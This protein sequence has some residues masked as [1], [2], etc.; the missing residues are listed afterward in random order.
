MN[1][2]MTSMT[3]ILVVLELLFKTK[4][5][6]ILFKPSHE[7]TGLLH[8]QKKTHISFACTR[9]AD[10]RLSFR[11]SDSSNPL[12]PRSEISSLQSPSVTAQP[13]LC[14]TRSETPKTG[15]LTTR[16]NFNT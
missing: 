7:K 4:I 14:R 1:S 6:L 15:F 3:L 11:F 5:A 9:E 12:L 2:S 8:M 10:Q 13:G 16:L